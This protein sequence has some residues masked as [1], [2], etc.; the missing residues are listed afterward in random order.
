MSEPLLRGAEEQLAV[1]TQERIA[2]DVERDAQL[3]RG[4]GLVLEQQQH[5]TQTQVQLWE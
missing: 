5:V 2:F 1:I 3:S 4:I